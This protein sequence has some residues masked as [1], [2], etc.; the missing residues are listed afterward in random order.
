MKN[1]IEFLK[2][3]ANPEQFVRNFAKQNPSPMMDNLIKMAEQNDKQG[4]EDV[5]RNVFNEKGQ[6]FDQIIQLLNK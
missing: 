6:N 5:A 2:M 4:I 1:P 3:I